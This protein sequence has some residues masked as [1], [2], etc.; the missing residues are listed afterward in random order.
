QWEPRLGKVLGVEEFVTRHA[1]ATTGREFLM[2]SDENTSLAVYLR[3]LA[4]GTPI[5]LDVTSVE[6]RD[7]LA[8][9]KGAHDAQNWPAQS[10]VR[11]L[12]LPRE[13][14]PEMGSGTVAKRIARTTR[15]FPDLADEPAIGLGHPQALSMVQR[16]DRC[17][18]SSA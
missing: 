2:Q 4:N 15:S 6:A 5:T 11:G 16:C 7:A 10:F 3:H 14:R 1:K 18:R 12:P 8:R 13:G 9:G 17:R